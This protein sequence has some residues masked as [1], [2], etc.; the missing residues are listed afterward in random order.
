MQEENME[1]DNEKEK[2]SLIDDFEKEKEMFK[3]SNDEYEKLLKME[4]EN[5]NN[6]QMSASQLEK[7]KD[8]FVGDRWAIF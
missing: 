1:T 2:K 7:N 3:N 5:S 4:K 6:L 8:D